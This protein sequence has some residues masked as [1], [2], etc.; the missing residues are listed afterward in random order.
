MKPVIPAAVKNIAHTD[1]ANQATIDAAIRELETYNKASAAATS[2]LINTISD[3]QMYHIRSV[4]RGPIA[5]WQKL[6]AKNERISEMEGE[7]VQKLLM[8]SP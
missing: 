5:T 3:A 7:V 8:C 1:N 2:H 6:R 4:N